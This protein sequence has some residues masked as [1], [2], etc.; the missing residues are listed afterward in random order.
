[1]DVRGCASPL[2]FAPTSLGETRWHGAWR[3]AQ[4]RQDGTGR[5]IHWANNPSNAASAAAIRR[6]NSSPSTKA[7]HPPDIN[8]ARAAFSPDKGLGAGLFI[9]RT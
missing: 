6:W 9:L 4:R 8:P 2:E 5:N 3:S 7:T 1:M